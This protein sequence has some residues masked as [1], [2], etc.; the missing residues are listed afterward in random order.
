VGCVG[1]FFFP[2]E[3]EF[4]VPV[5][6]QVRRGSDRTRR[7]LVFVMRIIHKRSPF[8]SSHHD[9]TR[10]TCYIWYKVSQNGTGRAFFSFSLV[11]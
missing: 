11:G 4:A 7:E 1:G 2:Q 10:S 3:F 6:L 5:S 9:C 8:L